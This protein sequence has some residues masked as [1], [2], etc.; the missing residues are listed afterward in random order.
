MVNVVIMDLRIKKCV[1]YNLEFVITEVDCIIYS[2]ICVKKINVLIS[3]YSLHCD[4]KNGYLK[5]RAAER[6]IHLNSF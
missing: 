1:C 4:N 2:F 5:Q 3:F 6:N